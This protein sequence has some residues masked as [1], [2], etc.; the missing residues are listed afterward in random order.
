MLDNPQ[1]S[2]MES[3]ASVGTCMDNDSIET[4]DSV[5]LQS[6]GNE[7]QILEA[8]EVAHQKNES[9]KLRKE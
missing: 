6:S 2:G 8:V 4:T 7:L 9:L 5:D 1:Q 3:P